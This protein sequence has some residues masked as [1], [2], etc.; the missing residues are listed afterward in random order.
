MAALR[1]R[2]GAPADAAA[3]SALLY[4]FDGEALAAA[5][6]VERMAQAQGLETVFLGELDGRLAGLLVLRTVPTLSDEGERAEIS[7]LYV[8]S[9]DRRQGLGRALVGAAV[10]WARSQ[11][12]NEIH[13]LVDPANKQALSLYEAAGFCRHSWEV[14]RC[15]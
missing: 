15:L 13:L 8:R 4:E 3:I 14:R 6:L 7:E 5:D 12:C 2:V 1:V 9:A 11:G 10:D